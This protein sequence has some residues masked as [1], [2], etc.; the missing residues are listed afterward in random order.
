[1]NSTRLVQQ[2]GNAPYYRAD[3]END[4]SDFRNENNQ[5]GPGATPNPPIPGWE[6]V[7]PAMQEF[8]A[9]TNRALEVQGRL[10][11]AAI[12]L[13][14]K[15]IVVDYATGTTDGSGNLDL[16]IYRVP[17]GFQ[18]I[19]TRV[20]VE[21]GTHTPGAGFTGA[22][23]WIGLM[24]GDKWMPGSLVDFWPVPAAGNAVIIPIQFTDGSSEAAV[25]RGGET[26]GLHIAT[27]PVSS[28]IWV[29]IQG[30]MEP[31]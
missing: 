25:F 15:R 19:T 30:L 14:D 4:K 10:L 2:A 23:S 20:N 17:V 31:I 9:R 21:D 13:M 29:R 27:G 11:Q 7:G 12:P 1:M 3:G 5:L 6:S 22:T 16:V 28:D 26:I 18:F 24:R 8:I